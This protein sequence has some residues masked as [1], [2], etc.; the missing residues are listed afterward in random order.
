MSKTN[1]ESIPAFRKAQRD[2]I[3]CRDCHHGAVYPRDR[4]RVRL[5]VLCGFNR[6]F[7]RVPKGN[8]CANAAKRVLSINPYAG[9]GSVEK[10]NSS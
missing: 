5:A 3:Q 2:E 8:T 6:L 7:C 4:V 1:Q 9:S 10:G